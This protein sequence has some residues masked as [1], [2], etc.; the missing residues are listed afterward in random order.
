MELVLN[1]L[2]DIGDAWMHIQQCSDNKVA[3]QCD[4]LACTWASIIE[5]YSTNIC[6]GGASTSFLDARGKMNNSGKN[7][8][9]QFYK[10]D[11]SS[12][13]KCVSINAVQDPSVLSFSNFISSFIFISF[14]VVIVLYSW[15]I[16]IFSVYLRA[17]FLVSV[18]LISQQTWDPL[19]ILLCIFS[20]NWMKWA[21]SKN[22]APQRG[23][24][25][26]RKRKGAGSS[27]DPSL[28]CCESFTCIRLIRLRREY[29]K[30]MQSS[31]CEMWA[32]QQII[33]CQESLSNAIPQHLQCPDSELR[34]AAPF[35]TR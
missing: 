32:V 13:C 24:G 5:N 31:T 12:N 30:N 20:Q 34:T 9:F 22:T 11:S 4:Y 18:L 16:H 3:N 26:A 21:D 29:I 7:M 33:C 6:F 10:K 27:P 25:R 14:F 2:T 35:N 8:F 19:L 15:F 1:T 23:R 17:S 28:R